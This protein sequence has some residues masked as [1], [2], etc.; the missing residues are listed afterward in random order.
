M[1]D[2]QIRYQSTRSSSHRD[3]YCVFKPFV[4]IHM[5]IYE[6]THDDLL[7]KKV[8]SL[9][10]P[11]HF[12]E[13]IL[14]R[15]QRS[16]REV[17]KRVSVLHLGRRIQF[18]LNLSK[19]YLVR[20]TN[21]FCVQFGDENFLPDSIYN[22]SSSD[23]KALLHVTFDRNFEKVIENGIVM[24][25]FHH[26]RPYRHATCNFSFQQTLFTNLSSVQIHVAQQQFWLPSF[27]M[28]LHKFK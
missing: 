28:K 3:H 5:R 25:F 17:N 2:T 7:L 9:K 14:P 13:G 16:L 1:C 10:M 8:K 21:L 4:S 18:C 6:S 12:G 27:K 20:D 11:I 22:M 23:L 24:V 15:S 19:T 26:F